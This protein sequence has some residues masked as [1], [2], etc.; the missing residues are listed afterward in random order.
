[1]PD[2]PESFVYSFTMRIPGT[3]NVY[4][5]IGVTKD[6]ERR[7][8]EINKAVPGVLSVDFIIP[9]DEQREAAL[10]SLCDHFSI[11]NEWF[12]PLDLEFIRQLLSSEIEEMKI[13]FP[14]MKWWSD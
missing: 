13:L 11:G 5:K 14:N 3:D 1:M 10:H 6:P 12:W 4:T 9:G 2:R 8:Y 7:F